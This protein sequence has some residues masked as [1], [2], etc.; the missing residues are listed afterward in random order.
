MKVNG[1]SLSCPFLYVHDSIY[2]LSFNVFEYVL[3]L[4]WCTF[5]NLLTNYFIFVLFAAD[6]NNKNSNKTDSPRATDKN[7]H[8]SPRRQL[9][10]SGE[11]PPPTITA[12]EIQQQHQLISSGTLRP[13]RPNSL[14][15]TPA[16][17]NRRILCYHNN[18][19]PC[20]NSPTGNSSPSSILPPGK[21][22]E[23]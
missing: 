16:R 18:N 12:S 23:P 21:I 20:N 10:Q 1:Y 17:L 11:P 6:F 22:L 9:K 2:V 19:L 3:D 7:E 14:G 4:L 8:C 15:C 13:E 5:D